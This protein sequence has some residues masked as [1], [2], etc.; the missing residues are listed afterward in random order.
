[1]IQNI[2]S[3]QD[4]EGEWRAIVILSGGMDSAA[5]L[6]YVVNFHG[7]KNVYA[8]TFDYG[9]R[10]I[11][12]MKAAEEL[13]KHYGVKHIIFRCDL[14]QIGGSA[15]TNKDI[16]V[17]EFEKDEDIWKKTGSALTYVPMRN[18]IFVSVAAAFAEVLGCSWIYTG[19][20]YIDSGGYPDTRPEYVAAMN[21]LLR[22]G[23]RDQPVLSTP[24]IMYTK[25]EIVDFGRGYNVPWEKTWSCYEGG[26]KPCGKCN[27][28]IQRAKG[29]SEAG[30]VDPLTPEMVVSRVEEKPSGQTSL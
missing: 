8:L 20:N 14:G 16:A 17:P 2:D 10:H 27:A 4:I 6:G 30:V 9:Q 21:A 22:V 3:L 18:T 13:A 26:E 7:A 11:K 24:L 29:F 25:K 19:F 12:E 23:S 1:M 28:C 5:V 15:L